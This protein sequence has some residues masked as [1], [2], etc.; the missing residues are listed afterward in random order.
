[1]SGQQPIST[2]RELMAVLRILLAAELGTFSNGNP[3]IWVE[4]PFAPTRGA[5]L[6]CVIQRQPSVL[7]SR[8]NPGN[9]ANQIYEWIVTLT[10]EQTNDGL[11]AMDAACNK[12]R[13]RFPRHREI[14]APLVDGKLP[15][16]T[17]QLTYSRAVN[18]T[19]I[20]LY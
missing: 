8:T 3:A 11:A 2:S 17:F 20:Q 18:C 12:L 9:Q 1:M 16:A 6:H 19:P 4:P 14:I 13:L 15:Q 5:G 7:S 10:V